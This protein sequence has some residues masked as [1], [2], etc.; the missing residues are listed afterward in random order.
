M[1]DFKKVE[2]KWKEYW[3]KNKTF[4]TDTTDFSKPKYYALDMF[5]YPSG[6][7]LHIG[8]IEGYTAT[9]IVS[10]MKRMQGFN[11]LHPIGF[12][13]F[14]LQAEHF[15]VK[16][17]H[18]PSVFTYQNIENFKKQLR[19]AGLSYDWDREIRTCDSDYYHWT[20]WIFE[21]LYEDGLAEYKDLPVN[22]CEEL[23]TVLSNDEIIDGKS[24]RGGYPVVRKNMKQWSLKITKYAEKLLEGHK[25][26]DWPASTILMQKN[27][28]GKSVGAEVVFKIDGFS[29]T[30]SVFTTRADTLFGATY[31]VLAPEHKLIEKITT[32]EQKSVVDEY[33][34]ECAKKSEL[35]RT[36]LNKEKTGVFCGAYA[37]NPV[38]N[39][40]IPIFVADYVLGGYGSGAV[41]AVPAHDQRDWEFAKKHNLK[42]V[43][44]VMGGDITK[45]A[46][47]DDGKHIN[48]GFLNGL[49]KQQAL[50]K[51]FE[52]LEKNK[53]GKKTTNYKLRDWIFGRQRYWGE[54]IPV[55][56]MEDGTIKLVKKSELPLV[57][58]ELEDY[59][60]QNGQSP[61]ERAEKW[62]NVVIDG[63][64][65]K[66][67]TTTMPSATASSWYFLRY[68]DPQN[69]TSIGDKKLLD[70]WLPVDL[71]VGGAEHA[72]GHLLYSRFFNR[73]LSEKGYLSHAE[74]F[75]KL[76]HPGM[77]L[78]S[79][80]EKMSKSKGNVINPDD[81]IDEYG[82]DILRLYEM[83]MGPI[84]ESKPWQIGGIEGVKRFLEKVWKLFVEESVV[85][86]QKTLGL[87][88]IYH[89]TVKKVT[90][91]YEALSFN[92]AISQMMIFMNAVQAEKKIN[93]DYAEGFLK[94]LNPIAPCITEEV[95]SLFGHKNTI[96]YEPWPTFDEEKTKKET[97]ELVVQINGK[98]KDK[99]LAKMNS[100]EE[101]IKKIALAQEKIKQ[102]TKDK[103]IL[104]VIVIK[105]KLVNI[106]IKG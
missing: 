67:E 91:D 70:H 64:K 22:W 17:G 72:V 98:V 51:M 45:Q 69:K 71:Y 86:D 81:V 96:S 62:K 66:R 27:W 48:S 84:T 8:H 92:T 30:F 93:K 40:K 46:F 13:A 68:V 23:G 54:P 28:I 44:V 99:L 43:Q 31:C 14:G 15:A 4:K 11:V 78:G 16:T 100:S 49:N 97:F 2:Q 29:E 73:F 50:E 24:E 89:Q 58:P 87:E 101:E 59:K 61:L 25:D 103:E 6:Q 65:G 52:Y 104:K 95:W 56:H 37:I 88:K 10:R 36:E 102:A 42:M 57:L 3:V 7:G 75:K 77:I 5:P 32:K 82:C 39:Q 9:D 19:N 105:N 80:S 47:E 74:P 12:D 79:N 106:V 94:L 90:N 55:V 1:Y 38:N 53:I 60:P 83:F 85:T 18:H 35:E 26:L 41:M 20:Q 63:K 34:K 33:V 21:K 76:V